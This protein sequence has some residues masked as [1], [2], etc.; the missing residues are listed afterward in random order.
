[1]LQS[2]SKLFIIVNYQVNKETITKLFC[3]NKAKPVLKCNGKCHLKKQLEKE[4]KKENAP[5]NNIKTKTEI[6]FFSEDKLF[7]FLNNIRKQDQHHSLY[8]FSESDSHL[9]SVF[10]PPAC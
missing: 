7:A 9:S 6:Q 10:H 1:M 8:L 4:E 2:V 5:S 3:E